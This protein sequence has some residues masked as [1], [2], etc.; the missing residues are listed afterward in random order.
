MPEI[1]DSKY[2]VTAGWDDAPHLDPKAKEELLSS[3]PPYLRD[4]RSKGIPSLGSGA[5][6]PI[7]EDEISVPYFDIPVYWPRCTNPELARRPNRKNFAEPPAY[8]PA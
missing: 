6:Y 2:L 4:A 1:T 5:I 7:S 8:H 3:I